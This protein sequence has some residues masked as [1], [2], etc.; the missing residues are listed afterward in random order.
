LKTITHITPPQ[1]I[2]PP[3]GEQ[4][5]NIT[6]LIQIAIIEDRRTTVSINIILAKKPLY[7]T[8]SP[9]L[10]QTSKT[11]TIK[12]Y[13]LKNKGINYDLYEFI[14]LHLILKVLNMKFNAS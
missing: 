3:D 8:K 4:K 12:K 9:Q 2:Y 7:L 11:F 5:Q 1:D 6:S 10:K 13:H 14:V